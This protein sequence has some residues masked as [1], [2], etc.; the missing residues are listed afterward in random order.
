MSNKRA[1]ELGKVAVLMGGRSAE[2]DIS[3]R[4]GSGVL[5]ALLNKGVDAHPFDPA[6][7]PF[8]K[9]ADEKFA[10]AFI[11]LHGR[12]GE[13]GTIQGMLELLGIPYTGS[14]VMASALAMN[15]VM[16]KRIWMSADLPTPRYILLDDNADWEKVVARLGLPLI[17]KPAHEGSSIGIERVKTLQALPGAYKRAKQF[18]NIVFAEEF[19]KGMELTCAVLDTEDGPKALPLV[20]VIAPDANYDYENKYFSKKT[21]YLCPS[22]IPPAL[23][24]KIQADVLEA[25]N[26]LG[27]RGWGRADIMLRE[28]DM[29]AFILEMNTSPGMTDVSLVPMAARET[30]IDYEELCLRILELARL[31]N[32]KTRAG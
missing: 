24:E 23:E 29:S 20:R 1:S 30:G 4:S 7:E 14:G 13:D 19:I 22:G 17:V 6:R 8:H 18:D 16:T 15:K 26:M 12:Y 11:T 32:V 28:E 31:D 5:E 2:R 3:L 27:C 25:Y 21:I 10:R 9:L